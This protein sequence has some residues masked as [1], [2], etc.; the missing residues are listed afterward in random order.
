MKVLTLTSSYPRFEGD[1][2]GRFIRDLCYVL[3]EKGVDISVLAPRARTMGNLPSKFDVKRFPYLPS[4]RIELLSDRTMKG[5]PLKHLLQLPPYMLSAYIHLLSRPSDIIHAHLAIP[6]GYLGTLDPRGTPLVVTCHGSDCT[7]PFTNP[8]YRPMTRL[9]LR[10]ADRVIA[11]SNFIKKLAIA[12]GATPEKTDV[13][14]IGVDIEKFRPSDD[15]ETLK[16]KIGIPEDKTVVGTLGR[17]VPDKRVV[18]LIRAAPLIFENI[19]VCFLV[20]G[21]GPQRSYLEDAASKIGYADIRF[22]REVWDAPSFHRLC[23]IF[24]LTSIR[25]GLSISLQES[26]ATGCVPVVVNGFGCSELVKEGVNGF[27]FK[28]GDIAELADKVTLA[29]SRL[30]LGKRARYTIE[31]NFDLDKNALK[32]LEL[33]ETLL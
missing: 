33:Y 14:Y 2:H 5:A 30:G 12:L 29:A 27:L 4:Q 15:K 25:E 26:M 8:I 7:L 17:L 22:L 20:G 28:P 10:K 31:Q 19:D 24:V 21:D 13:I 16:A 32:Y 6:L 11:V 9:T 3:Q 1:Y 23:D 18:D